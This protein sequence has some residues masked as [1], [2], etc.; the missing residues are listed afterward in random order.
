MSKIHSTYGSGRTLSLTSKD[1]SKSEERGGHSPFTRASFSR[2]HF[3][4]VLFPPPRYTCLVALACYRALK[5]EQTLAAVPQSTCLNY[6]ER[7]GSNQAQTSPDCPVWGNGL[8]C[9]DGWPREAL[10]RLTW[11]VM[12]L[13]TTTGPICFTH[14]DNGTKD[15]T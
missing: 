11:G 2:E 5:P 1:C 7:A 8:H 6:A 4:V 13:T 15:Q 9:K 14:L 3:A 10:T 12:A